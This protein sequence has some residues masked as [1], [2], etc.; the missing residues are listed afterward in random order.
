MTTSM[1]EKPPSRA[2]CVSGAGPVTASGVETSGAG[3]TGSSAAGTGAAGAG[4]ASAGT[5]GTEPVVVGM[6]RHSLVGTRGLG[7]RQWYVCRAG[8]VTLTPLTSTYRLVGDAVLV[9]RTWRGSP[10]RPEPLDKARAVLSWL[11]RYLAPNLGE[12]GGNQTAD[13]GNV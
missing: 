5:A 9:R 7:C 12:M 8:V 10:L 3:A 6:L 2:R 13:S 4:T 1:S 11:R